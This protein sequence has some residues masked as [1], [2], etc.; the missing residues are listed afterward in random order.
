M[1]NY[2]N[3][4]QPTLPLESTTSRTRIL[5]FCDIGLVRYDL[6]IW[7][8]IREPFA[9]RTEIFGKLYFPSDLEKLMCGWSPDRYTILLSDEDIEKLNEEDQKSLYTIFQEE[10]GLSELSVIE[11]NRLRSWIR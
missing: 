10:K 11:L 8:A 3:V 1:T 5:Y 9:F 7:E 2:H 6:T 4:E